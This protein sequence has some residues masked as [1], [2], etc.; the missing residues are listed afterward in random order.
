LRSNLLIALVG[1]AVSIAVVVTFSTGLNRG[2]LSAQ[3]PSK[4]ENFGGHSPGYPILGTTGD[5]LD[6]TSLNIDPKTAVVDPMKYLREFNYGRTSALSNGTSL[7]E[8]TLIASDQQT[9][10]VSPGVFYNVWTFNGT[11]PGPTIRA[12]EGDLVRVTLIN[13]GTKFHSIHF[14]GIHRS[15][16]DG[17]FEGIAPGGKFT[18]EFT[19]EPFGVFPYHCHMQPLEE[20][21]THGLYGVFIIDPKKPRADADEMVMVMN[22]YDTDF[23]T[24]NNFYTVNGIPYYYM[25]H[26]IQ[27]DKNRLIR[28]YLLNILEIDTI[29]NF[30]L[31]A[32]MFDL[33][34]TG[35][36]LIPDEYTDIVTMSQGERGILEFSYK[37]PGKYMFHAHKTEFAEKGWVGLF[38]V[39][40]STA[41]PATENSNFSSVERNASYSTSEFSNTGNGTTSFVKTGGLN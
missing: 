37:Y 4:R 15:E 6:P 30:N 12:T 23:D 36:K 32:N 7:R 29:N 2:P 14:H 19:A 33:Y 28:I 35:T 10:E 8:F 16:M 41:E 5:V 27:I 13:N 39:K 9:K 38:L 31:H 24:E 34:R 20:H 3:D 17:V 11:I 21:I 26:P 40:D 18:Y 1:V 22:G 25:H